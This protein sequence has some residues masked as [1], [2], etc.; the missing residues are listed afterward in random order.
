MPGSHGLYSPR[1]RNSFAC[2]Q[3][4][5]VPAGALQKLKECKDAGGEEDEVER[6]CLGHQIRP[7]NLV[8][9]ERPQALKDIGRWL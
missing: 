8:D 1:L 7:D 3:Q 5:T 2:L 9:N 4:R 6:E